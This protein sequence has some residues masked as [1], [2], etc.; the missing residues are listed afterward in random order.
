MFRSVIAVIA[1]AVSQLGCCCCTD[2]IKGFQK[3]FNAGMQK[4]QQQQ[5]DEERRR[6]GNDEDARR[7]ADLAQLLAK[8]LG[9]NTFPGALAPASPFWARLRQTKPIK[10]NPIGGGRDKPFSDLHPDGGVLIGLV[11][12][13]DEAGQV[14]AFLQPIY[15]TSQ[16]QKSARPTASRAGASRSS[17]RKPVTPSAAPPCA[18]ARSWMPSP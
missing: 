16:G 9:P 8:N 12:G 4:A 13:E 15:L 18:W 6:A 5:A 7:K 10:N 11:A 14:I 3:G 2:F 17:R 1:V